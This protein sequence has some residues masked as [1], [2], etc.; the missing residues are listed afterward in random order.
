MT[1]AEHRAVRN[2]FIL[3]SALS[4]L[5]E[6][7]NGILSMRQLRLLL[8][9]LILP[10]ITRMSIVLHIIANAMGMCTNHI[11]GHSAPHNS[12]HIFLP[13]LAATVAITMLLVNI[14]TATN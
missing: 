10:E 5:S 3:I 14:F 12:L 7:M 2:I 13:A 9:R 1:P 6:R 11:Y 8:Q 4:T